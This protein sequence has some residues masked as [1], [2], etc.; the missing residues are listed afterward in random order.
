MRA[1]L[2]IGLRFTTSRK[3]SLVFNLLGVVFGVAFF[4]CTQAQTQGFEQYFISTILGTSGAIVISDRF[5]NRYTTFANA[6]GSTVLS[7]QQRRKYYEG[8]TDP[9]EIM[10][11]ARTFSN[12]AACAPVVQGNVTARGDFQSEVMTIQ[13]IDLEL[14]LRATA[15][16]AQIIGGSL[17]DYR[18]KPNGVIMGSLLADKMQLKV[19]DTR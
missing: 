15:L 10:R 3:R 5:Q 8:I 12:V 2:Y 6:A 14:Q 16:R 1:S 9:A 17:D 18:R 4:V 7:G 13:G 11:V 19:G